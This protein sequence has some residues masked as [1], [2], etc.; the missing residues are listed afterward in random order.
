VPHRASIIR[1]RYWPASDSCTPK[2]RFIITIDHHRSPP[3]TIARRA[4]ELRRAPIRAS[5]RRCLPQGLSWSRYQR[6]RTG[7]LEG[8]EGLET[9][10]KK[11]CVSGKLRSAHSVIGRRP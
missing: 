9:G 4:G 11:F 5:R 10:E 8:L 2:G 3:I 6:G 1:C 7:A